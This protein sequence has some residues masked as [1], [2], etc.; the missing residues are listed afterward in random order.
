MKLYSKAYSAPPDTEGIRY[1]APILL[2]RFVTPF[3]KRKVSGVW[4]PILLYRFVTP[5]L[6]R[7][8]PV[9]DRRFYYTVLSLRNCYEVPT[10][11]FYLSILK[12]E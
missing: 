2:Y 8:Y 6:K 3:L 11:F 10:L 9:Y 4:P 12:L 1:Q 5:F 7:K